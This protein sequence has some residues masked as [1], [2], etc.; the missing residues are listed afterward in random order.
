MNPIEELD[1]PDDGY[2]ARLPGKPHGIKSQKFL[3]KYRKE[4]EKIHKEIEA[5][6]KKHGP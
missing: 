1:D 6:L 5:V 2:I 3:K 4:L